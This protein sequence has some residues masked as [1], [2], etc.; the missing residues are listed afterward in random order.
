MDYKSY[1]DNYSKEISNLLL[2]VN[3]DLINETVDLIKKKE[4]LITQFIL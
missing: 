2:K 1:Y 3:T 4:I